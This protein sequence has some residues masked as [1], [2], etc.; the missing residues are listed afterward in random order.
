[1]LCQDRAERDTHRA[2]QREQQP[3]Q[4]F[5]AGIDAVAANQDNDAGQRHQ[6]RDRA[7]Q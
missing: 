7:D 1:M 4:L 6:K 2:R 3:R 5:K